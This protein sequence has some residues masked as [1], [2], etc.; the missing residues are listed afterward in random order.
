MPKSYSAMRYEK[1]RNPRRIKSRDI[2]Y[3][4]V[5]TQ[6][7][8]RATWSSEQIIQRIHSLRATTDFFPSWGKLSDCT[9]ESSY[10]DYKAP[11]AVLGDLNVWF[12]SFKSN[13]SR[14][15]G[16]ATLVHHYV[17]KL[18]ES[19][20]KAKT[21]EIEANLAEANSNRQLLAALLQHNWL[22]LKLLSCLGASNG[23]RLSD[24]VSKLGALPDDSAAILA[25]LTQGGVVRVE[26]DGSFM[27]TDR[28]IDILKNLESNTGIN[29]SPEN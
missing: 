20:T 17:S 8:K 26:D 16:N 14:G 24:L 23:I 22:G 15:F 10:F 7:L 4:R 3:V 28:G 2:Q 21:A 18:R 11:S 1:S 25:Q 29:V 19:E 27:C 9:V 13:L 5:E 6:S 12:S